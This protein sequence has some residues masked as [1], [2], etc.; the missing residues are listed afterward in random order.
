MA[1]WR[2]MR[3][4]Y[5]VIVSG[6]Y[7]CDLIF[8]G[9]PE[10]PALGTEVFG[11]GFDMVPGGMFNIVAALRRMGL[12]VGWSVTYG[13]D[14]FSQFFLNEARR[15]G[16]DESLFRYID[17]PRRIITASFSLPSDRGFISYVEPCEE[18]DEFKLLRANH[19][20]CYM[21]CAQWSN[22]RINEI[23]AEV[24]RQDGLYFMDP[25]YTEV[26]LESPGVI[27]IIKGIDVFSPNE[28]EALKL[29]GASDIETAL[30]IL[31]TYAT[32]VVIKRGPRGAIAQDQHN[33]AAVPA[34]PVDVVDTTGAGDC[35]NAGFISAY[36]K[37]ESLET[38]LLYGNICGGLSTTARGVGS[39]PTIE[40]VKQY[41]QTVNK[42]D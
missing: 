9:L 21:T 22:P 18:V 37:G 7:F 33:K 10:I 12:H 35:F 4:D 6:W 27:E 24:H 8:T 25:Q 32:L 3:I 26:T 39:A 13:N 36:L 1:E 41:I 17:K 2:D 29:T 38:C 19:T 15:E 40:K 31:C 30:D 14:F 20:R 5:D 23:K 34:I 16:L 42:P 28:S 11:T